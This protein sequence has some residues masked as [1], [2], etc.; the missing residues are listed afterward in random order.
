LKQGFKTLKGSHALY[1][2]SGR[3]A[4]LGISPQPKRDVPQTG[5]SHSAGDRAQG[6]EPPTRALSQR[7]TSA[8]APGTQQNRPGWS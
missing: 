7:E 6:P 1:P 3:A 4:A 5:R 2:R 8:L